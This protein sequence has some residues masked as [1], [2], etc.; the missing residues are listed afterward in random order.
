MY[1]KKFAYTI[2]S[3]SGRK[4][5]DDNKFHF[6]FRCSSSLFHRHWQRQRRA[7]DK[8]QTSACSDDKFSAVNR[9][10]RTVLFVFCGNCSV[11]AVKSKRTYM[12]VIWYICE[13]LSQSE[14]VSESFFVHPPDTHVLLMS[15]TPFAMRLSHHNAPTRSFTSSF[16]FH[17]S[18]SFL[19]IFLVFFYDLFSAWDGDQI[20]LRI[21]A[22]NAWNGE[23]EKRTKQTQIS[24]NNHREKKM[25]FHVKIS[26]LCL[27]YYYHSVLS[28]RIRH[29]T[30]DWWNIKMKGVPQ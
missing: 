10:K 22:I 15:Y 2:E 25:A 26:N 18:H 7:R 23:I 3:E 27:Y 24:S 28:L 14:R 12:R 8:D 13:R 21:A 29:Q 6:F 4:N 17:V 1:D 30:E 20:R 19:F 5:Y 9:S 11:T 16:S